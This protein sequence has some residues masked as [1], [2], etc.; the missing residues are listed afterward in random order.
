MMVQSTTVCYL[1]ATITLPRCL[2]LVIVQ[3]HA[4]PH[5]P[6]QIGPGSLASDTTL[7][8]TAQHSSPSTHKKKIR[9]L[10][11]SRVDPTQKSFSS[12]VGCTNTY[13]TKLYPTKNLGLLLLAL[14]K[15]MP[16]YAA[17]YVPHHHLF[18]PFPSLFI[19]FYFILFFFFWWYVATRH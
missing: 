10:R 7:F 9:S 13:C 15:K 5:N 2:N 14:A 12:A 3:G 8:F 1:S 18:L 16:G 11:K 6:S 4:T 19:L 17:A